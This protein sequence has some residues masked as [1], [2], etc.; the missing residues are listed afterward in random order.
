MSWLGA[1]GAGALASNTVVAE[2]GSAPNEGVKQKV[3]GVQ[4]DT[5]LEEVKQQVIDAI[6][7]HVKQSSIVQER[8]RNENLEYF[9]VELPDG[10][11]ESKLDSINEDLDNIDD[12]EYHH[13]NYTE[14]DVTMEAPNDPRFGDQYAPQLVNSA[15]AWDQTFG[16]DDVTIAVVDTGTD[17]NHEDL[18]SR[19]GSNKGS[20]FTADDSDPF[21]DN[22][23]GHGT[24]VSGC[25]SADTDNGI[26]VAGPVDSTLLSVRVLGGG[27]TEISGVADGIQWAADQGADIINMSLGRLQYDVVRQA[28]KYA[29]NKGSLQ[30]VA[31]GNDGVRG[32]SY[33]A[34]W[35]ETVAVSAL[36][37]N[38][39]LANFSQYG[40]SIEVCAPGVNVL[41]TT[42]NGGYGKK[43]GTSM[44]CPV[45]AG[46]AALGLA[47]DPDLSKSEL[48][49]RLKETAVDIGLGSEEQG[50]GRVDAT[51]IVNAGSDGDGGDGDDGDD[52]GDGDD[53]D[54]GGDGDDGDDGGDGD[55][56]DDGGQCSQTAEDTIN[57]SL[58]GWWDDESWEWELEFENTCS[59]EIT[60]EGPSD[61]DFDLYVGEGYWPSRYRND[62]SSTGSDSQESITVD[63][64]SEDLG[65]L[66]AVDSH[67]GDGNYTVSFTETGNN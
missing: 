27:N 26:G 47:A 31:A 66:V 1:L 62:E 4:T 48:R 46:V 25:A 55:D 22:G 29:D 28:V 43:S 17:Y 13:Q 53:G 50:S 2:K 34:G 63:D 52:G 60:L 19:F 49:Q 15:G 12:L 5:D 9:T 37:P 18:S 7:S 58:S 59:V 36:D 21:P 40:P 45:A 42:V 3:C 11:D 44:A 32:V 35:D 61:A 10:L 6:Q 14:K 23:R 41:S 51:A 20:D 16:S 8:K 54:D 67:A 24:H 30:I 64:V 57:S 56:G 33:P 65:I 39:N 38:E